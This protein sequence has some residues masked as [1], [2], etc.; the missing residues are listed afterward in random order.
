[1]KYSPQTLEWFKWKADWAKLYNLYCRR[2]SKAKKTYASLSKI[3]VKQNYDF[4]I[5]T[6]IKLLSCQ[7]K[8]LREYM[9]YLHELRFQKEIAHLEIKRNLKKNYK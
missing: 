4:E 2:I 6:Q 3:L 8:F 7:L 1:M 5:R 9:L